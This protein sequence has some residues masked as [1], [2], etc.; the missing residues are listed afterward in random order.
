MDR[1]VEVSNELYAIGYANN[2]ELINALKDKLNTKLDLLRI[3]NDFNWPERNIAL[4]FIIKF[5]L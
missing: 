3:Q 4:F 5:S 1:S 2:L